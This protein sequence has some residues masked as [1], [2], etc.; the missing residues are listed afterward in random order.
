MRLKILPHRAIVR[1]L[2]LA[3]LILLQRMRRGL[4]LIH[5][6]ETGIAI[7]ALAPLAQPVHGAA[8]QHL[9]V[10]ERVVGIA[11]RHGRVVGVAERV[12]AVDVQAVEGVP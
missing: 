1:T 10:A 8:L 2:G 12:L 11:R 4:E 9:L 6:A 5:H 7:A 3:I